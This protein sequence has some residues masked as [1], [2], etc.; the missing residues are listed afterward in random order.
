MTAPDWNS[1]HPRV[2]ADRARANRR[3]ASLSSQPG[4]TDHNGLELAPILSR[5]SEQELAAARRLAKL[6]MP[7]LQNSRHDLIGTDPAGSGWRFLREAVVAL[8]G[9]DPG[10]SYYQGGK[11]K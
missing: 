4:I 6:H 8:G 7:T 5:F 3:A 1:P 11:R 2:A 9:K 10:R